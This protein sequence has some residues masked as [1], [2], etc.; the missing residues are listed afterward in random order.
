MA[1]K[2]ISKAEAEKIAKTFVEEIEFLRQEAH[3]RGERFEALT[4]EQFV[5][6]LMAETSKSP[7]FNAQAWGST[8]PGGST[9]YT[10]FVRNPDPFSH[11][12]FVLFGYLFFGPA[13]FIG[14]VD[15][16]LT[17]FDGRF[18]RFYQRCGVAANS[19]TSMT[20][21]IRVGSSV[22]PGIYIGNCF[23]VQRNPFDVGTYLDRAGFDLTVT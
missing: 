15:A 20:F 16:A 6:K 9:T 21:T 23:L 2:S 3:E 4:E 22:Q 17:V 5:S 10:A 14:G 13:N 11:S 12:G 19:S 18:P 8:S 1:P 7:F